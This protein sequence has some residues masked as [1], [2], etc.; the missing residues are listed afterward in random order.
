MMTATV[1]LQGCPWSCFYCHNPALID[2]RAEGG[3]VGGRHRPAVRPDGAARRRRVLRRRAHAAARA[4]SGDADGALARLPRGPA[5]RGRL[6]GAAGPGAAVRR[7]GGPGHRH[8]RRLRQRHR[9]RSQWSPCVA[10]VGARARQPA[11]ARGRITRS[12]TRCARPCT[13]RRSTTRHS[14]SSD[15]VSPTR[16]STRGPCSGSAKR[17]RVSRSRVADAEA[18]ALRL[19]DLPVERFRSLVVR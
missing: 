19:D 5:H 6:P 14:A 18:P 15:A 11:A 8:A 12:T 3:V 13:R 1:F 7:L 2:P 10:I 16:A 4:R 17:E 9:A